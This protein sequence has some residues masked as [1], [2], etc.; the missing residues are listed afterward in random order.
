MASISVGNNGFVCGKKHI[1][2]VQHYKLTFYQN[3]YFFLKIFLKFIQLFNKFITV[4]CLIYIYE[5][6]LLYSWA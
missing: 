5:S 4:N 3:V 2:A 6:H 1:K